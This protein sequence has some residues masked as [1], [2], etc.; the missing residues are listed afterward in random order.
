[1]V[2]DRAVL[3]NNTVLEPTPRADRHAW[4]NHSVRPDL[5]RRV[6]LR[7]AV[8]ND[9]ALNRQFRACDANGPAK[10]RRANTADLRAHT[11]AGLRKQL[12]ALR[13][14]EVEVLAGRGECAGGVLDLAPEA[15]RLVDGDS[16][17][18]GEGHENVLFDCEFVRGA[19]VRA[20]RGATVDVVADACQVVEEGWC[21][22]V[23]AGVDDVGDVCR[24]PSGVVDELAGLD[25]HLAEGAVVGDQLLSEDGAVALGG[26][27]GGEEGREGE[28][29]GDIA[30]EDDY[31]VGR[32]LEQDVAVAV[33]AAGGAGLCLFAEVCDGDFVGFGHRV[34]EGLEE[35][36]LEK[37]EENDLGERRELGEG[38]YMVLDHRPAGD[39]KE[40]L[41]EVEGER[42]EA[43]RLGHAAH[44]DYGFCTR[45]GRRR[46]RH[47][48]ETIGE[49]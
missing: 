31:G 47:G 24:R 4:P 43:R 30:V 19:E 38:I 33:Q 45:G 7:T 6:Y 11:G 13:R 26:D 27:V 41:R 15:L 17:A 8:D 5:G 29:A 49:G 42:A 46:V 39:G 34:E 37:A 32:V 25:D 2:L 44:E 36:L 14:K 9:S 3:K 18:A 20:V 16:R 12:R 10:G 35:R 23:N 22:D 40:R 28:C 48:G 21:E 1:M